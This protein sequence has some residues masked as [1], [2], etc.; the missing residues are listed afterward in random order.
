MELF[1]ANIRKSDGI[2]LR[3]PK[4]FKGFSFPPQSRK[5]ETKTFTYLAFADDVILLAMD[6][7]QFS[8]M[9]QAAVD[10]NRQ[11]TS[12]HRVTR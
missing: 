6:R 5:L 4:D 1:D 7:E 10:S 9:L 12:F 8:R 11:R 2:S 3:V